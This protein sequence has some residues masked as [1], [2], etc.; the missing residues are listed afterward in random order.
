MIEEYT[1][2][3]QM[4]KSAVVLIFCALM[5]GIIAQ[6]EQ[7]WKI[8]F[9]VDPNVSWLKPDHKDI[10]Q[11]GNKLR[12]GFGISIDKMFTD[13]YAIGTGLNLMTTGGE[14]TYLREE[15]VNVAG[16]DEKFVSKITRSYS[17]KY[18]E[19]PLTLKLRTNEI[20]YIT[21]WGQMGLGLGYNYRAKADDQITYVKQ[22]VADDANTPNENEEAWVD[23][24][25][26]KVE[27]PDEDASNDIAMFRTS[28]IAG[29]GIE[30]NISGSTSIVAGLIYNNGFGDVLKGK[31]VNQESNGSPKFTNLKASTFDLKSMNNF[32]GLQVGVLF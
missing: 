18:V 29:L 9:H 20:G 27:N 32:I 2:R 17:M 3:K 24:N 11:G 6:S 23:A 16:K 12:F 28:L 13:N 8:A 4:K 19:I 14:V 15:A 5:N 7:E 26:E 21:Y 10:E 25:L 31:G 30:Y 22:F 1:K